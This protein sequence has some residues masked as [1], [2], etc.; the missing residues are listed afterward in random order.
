MVIMY[1]Y[2]QQQQFV[3]QYWDNINRIFKKK[4]LFILRISF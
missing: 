4:N 3:F 2:I 1:T